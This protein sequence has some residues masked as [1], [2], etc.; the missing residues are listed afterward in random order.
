MTV[1]GALEFSW[2]NSVC[3]EHGLLNVCVSFF[4]VIVAFHL[5]Y[6]C[7]MPAIANSLGWRF[8][9]LYGGDS[10]LKQLHERYQVRMLKKIYLRLFHDYVYICDN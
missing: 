10:K 7:L 8:Y 3:Q 2:R 4:G 1:R 6:L 9:K 5:L